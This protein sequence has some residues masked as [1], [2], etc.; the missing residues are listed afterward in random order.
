MFGRLEIHSGCV[1]GALRVAR[2]QAPGS[3]A[4]YP[5]QAGLGSVSST[6]IIARPNSSRRVY[7]HQRRV[8]HREDGAIR[9]DGEAPGAGHR[10]YLESIGG[11]A[12]VAARFSVVNR[13]TLVS[14][15]K[16]L[17]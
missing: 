4:F 3:A 14:S 17:F 1:L 12:I 16:K 13:I 6:R 5:E 15:V 10:S 7:A 9:V 11:S 2:G 8:V